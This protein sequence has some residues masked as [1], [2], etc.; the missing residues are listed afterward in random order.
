MLLSVS[1]LVIFCVSPSLVAFGFSLGEQLFCS[2]VSTHLQDREW[3]QG[4][5]EGSCPPMA[6]LEEERK[7]DRTSQ[8]M[9]GRQEEEEH[10]NASSALGGKGP[11]YSLSWAIVAGLPASQDGWSSTL[12]HESDFERRETASRQG[13]ASRCSRDEGEWV[14]R[15]GLA[16]VR[17]G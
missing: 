12:I 16:R 3:M 6:S 8:S 13:R 10:C 17:S 4:M 11:K 1:D 2:E 14:V 5:C 7:R 15:R 9:Q